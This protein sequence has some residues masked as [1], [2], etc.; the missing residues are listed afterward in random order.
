MTADLEEIRV[1]G[2]FIGETETHWIYQEVDN[3]DGNE[4]WKFE[5]KKLR[6]TPPMNH[7]GQ[8]I[9]DDS[10]KGEQINGEWFIVGGMGRLI[11]FFPIPF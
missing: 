6:G 5:K 1:N 4:I 2:S 3:P 8:L 11:T 7:H 10:Y 9:L